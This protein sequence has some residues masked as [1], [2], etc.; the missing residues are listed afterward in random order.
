MLVI[1][2][3][4]VGCFSRSSAVS[5]VQGNR[6]RIHYLLYL[7]MPAIDEDEMQLRRQIFYELFRQHITNVIS[8]SL[9]TLVGLALTLASIFCLKPL[10]MDHSLCWVHTRAELSAQFK[11]ENSNLLPSAVPKNRQEILKITQ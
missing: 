7:D 4:S 5:S 6:R 8:G 10:S 3:P 1:R 9:V 11:A 2:F